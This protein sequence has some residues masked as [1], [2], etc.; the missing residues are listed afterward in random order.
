MDNIL[1]AKDELFGRLKRY[2]EVVGASVR[3]SETGKQYIVILLSR[4]T[5]KIISHIPTYY[6]G[7]EV[8]HEIIGRVK[9]L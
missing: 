8:K 7:N 1:I 9:R 6:M 4:F 3:N 5:K 2:R